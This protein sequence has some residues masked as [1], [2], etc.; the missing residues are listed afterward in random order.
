MRRKD[1]MITKEK[2][3]AILEN[4]QW[5]VLST[6]SAGHEPY[7]VPVN[8]CVIDG[9]IYF[10]CAPEGMKID[11]ITANPG[12]SFCV[13]DHA[14]V[15]ADRFAVRYA[16]CI[17]AGVASEVFAQEKQAALEGLIHKYSRDFVPQGMKYIEKLRDHARV[18]RITVESVSGKA[19]E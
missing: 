12:V 18:F 6:V 15:L 5:G 19:R 16:S 17:V 11:N 3:L 13:V 10:H 8:Y 7:G 2:A 1:R 4:G 14:V 9:C